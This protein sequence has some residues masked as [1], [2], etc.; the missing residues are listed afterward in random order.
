MLPAFLPE[1][2]GGP[3]ESGTTV[4][5]RAGLGRNHLVHDMEEEVPDGV[6][7][8]SRWRK[9]SAACVRIS[10]G[11]MQDGNDCAC[12]R[13]ESSLDAHMASTRTQYLQ[14]PAI[15]LAS[16]K[17]GVG[18]VGPAAVEQAEIAAQVP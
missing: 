16:V 12:A 9:P 11:W 14:H 10:A 5:A 8:L 17:I 7:G 15:Q 18:N 2:S 3:S 4:P 6:R 1:L 13:R